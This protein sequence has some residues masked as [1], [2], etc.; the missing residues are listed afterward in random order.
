MRNMS[1]L[2]VSATDL[3]HLPLASDEAPNFFVALCKPLPFLLTG[4]G[5]ARLLLDRTTGANVYGC[6]AVPREQALAFSSSTATSI[7]ERAYRRVENA[8]HE[9]V[10]QSIATDPLEAFDAQI[11]RMRN[12]LIACLDLSDTET[13]IVFSPSGTDSQLHALLLSGHLMGGPIASVVVGADQTGSGTTHTAR[14]RHFSHCTA[15]GKT[16]TKGASIAGASQEFASIPVSLFAED[17]ARRSERGIDNAVIAAVDEQIALGRK[18]ILQTMDSSKLGW[19]APSDA[20]LREIRA[21]WPHDVQIVVDACQMRIGRPRLREY[22]ERGYIVLLTGSKFFTGPAFSGASLWPQS[23]N[24]R[25]AAADA[26][27]DGL[28][29]YATSFDLPPRWHRMRAALPSMP[30]YGQWLRWEAALEEMRAYYALSQTYRS[31]A[32]KRLG[33]AVS[34]AIAASPVLELLP[35]QG[36]GDG[37]DEDL[38][39]TIFAFFVKRDGVRL[40]LDAMTRIYRALNRD[41]ALPSGGAERELAATPCHIGQ[42]VALAAGTILRIA[43]GARLVS[44]AWSPDDE[45][46]DANLRAI[47]DQATTIVKKIE[48]ILDAHLER[49]V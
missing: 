12:K 27:P 15:Q 44:D 20:C 28:A 8:R 5:D 30:N 21:R 1:A 34:G 16:V 38:P 4:G 3:E 23:L 35:A 37:F 26:A 17:G 32:L 13:D 9:L 31:T 2:A 41:L 45:T 19:R 40:D 39:A 7:S 24:A 25:I 46:T 33:D 22:L 29:D 47:A 42:P 48:L 36:H 14:G 11:E 6:R 18:V 10:R 49:A 43:V